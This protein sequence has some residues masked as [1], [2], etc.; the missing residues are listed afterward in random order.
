LLALGRIGARENR[1]E[2]PGVA[3]RKPGGD[4]RESCGKLFVARQCRNHERDARPKES[5]AEDVGDFGV[6]VLGDSEAPP[7]PVRPS[8]KRPGDRLFTEVVLLFEIPERFELLAKR[9]ASPGV[10]QTQ[11]RELCLHEAVRFHSYPHFLLAAE[12]ECEGTLV[13]IDQGEPLPV[14]KDDERLSAVDVAVGGKDAGER[15][16][17]IGE[18][19]AAQ[20]HGR[21]PA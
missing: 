2:T 7:D 10:V 14:A 11:S 20:T 3:K 12:M 6:Q 5:V 8:L 9:G 17:D 19:N 21:S 15:Q 1:E 13:A 4:D 16:G 18:A